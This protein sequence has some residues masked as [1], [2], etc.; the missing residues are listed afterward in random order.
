[1]GGSWFADMRPLHVTRVRA[2]Y[3]Y[4]CRPGAPLDH[5]LITAAVRELPGSVEVLC[6]PNIRSLTIVFDPAVTDAERLAET[7]LQLPAPAEA[8][9]TAKAVIATPQRLRAVAL[10]AASLLASQGLQPGLQAP[11]ALGTAVPLDHLACPGSPGGRDFDWTARLS[12]REYHRFSAGAGRVSG[13]F[14]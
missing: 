8:G 5:R 11:V 9:T 13:T 1:M 2:R 10:S 6:K 7:L 3:R 12:C 4:R 14:H